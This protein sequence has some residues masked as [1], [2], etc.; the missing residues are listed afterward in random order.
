MLKPAILYKD[1]IVRRFQEKYYTED[2][3]NETG[4]NE[5]WVPDIL[6]NSDDSIFQYAIVN[7]SGDCVGY[8]GFRVDWYVSCAYNFGLISFNKGDIYVGLAMKEVLD[9]LINQFKLHRITWRM[10]SGN[11]VER[12]YDKF[13][14]KYHGNKCI[15]HDVMRDKYGNYHNDVVYEIIDAWKVRDDTNV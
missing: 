10:V 5:Q 7:D 14:H 9:M 2:M 1:Y 8:V 12:A 15:L 6:D 13:C 11:P 4:S 3:F